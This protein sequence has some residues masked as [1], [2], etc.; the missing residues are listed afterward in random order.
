MV[1]SKDPE[2][3]NIKMD[4]ETLKQVSEFKYLVSIFTKDGKN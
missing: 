3:I 1:C 2:N 4:D